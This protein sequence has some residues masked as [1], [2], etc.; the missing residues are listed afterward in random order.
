MGHIRPRVGSAQVPPG[1]GLML[2]LGIVA[3]SFDMS[4]PIRLKYNA[5][6]RL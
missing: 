3:L 1:L 2:E 6:S 5:S 4:Y